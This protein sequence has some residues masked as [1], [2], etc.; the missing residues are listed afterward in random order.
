[1]LER[2]RFEACAPR[3]LLPL[4]VV[5]FERLADEVRILVLLF[6]L[7]RQLQLLAPGAVLARALVALI[8]L[9][10]SDGAPLKAALFDVVGLA[11]G[12]ARF[13]SYL[14]ALLAQ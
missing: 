14:V 1:V 13:G 5:R 4:G 9:L 12:R 3:A 10:L 11:D 2:V 6:N 8:L 7:L